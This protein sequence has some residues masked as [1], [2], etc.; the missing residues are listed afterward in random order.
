[1][2]HDN[3]CA[4]AARGRK[5]PLN[6]S[7]RPRRF[8]GKFRSGLEGPGDEDKVYG[9]GR[10]IRGGLV[11]AIDDVTNP[12]LPGAAAG[13]AARLPWRLPPV[14]RRQGSSE[15]RSRPVFRRP[16][17]G[18]RRPTMKF[19]TVKIATSHRRAPQPT[20]NRHM[21]ARRLGEC[22]IIQRQRPRRGHPSRRHSAHG[23][24]LLSRPGG[25]AEPAARPPQL[26]ATG[27]PAILGVKQADPAG[28][29]TDGQTGE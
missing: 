8:S 9:P 26:A 16:S 11:K 1:M 4:A 17:V 14:E 24:E 5:T 19:K 29:Q 12:N 3:L 7:S 25:G 28:G 13:A 27:A 15:P 2:D 18:R 10:S 23:R 6:S 21:K 20:R 22:S